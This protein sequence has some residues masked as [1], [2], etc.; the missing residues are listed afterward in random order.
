MIVYRVGLDCSI[1]PRL[2]AGLGSS[3]SELRPPT[4]S[5]VACSAV[6]SCWYS[7]TRTRYCSATGRGSRSGPAGLGGP[8]RRIGQST[9]GD[10]TPATV[11]NPDGLLDLLTLW[12]PTISSRS[13]DQAIF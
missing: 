11:R 8:P 10:D 6:S 2:P 5:H 9:P 7:G 12:V 4:W 13:R 3:L 1:S